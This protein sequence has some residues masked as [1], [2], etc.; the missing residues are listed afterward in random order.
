MAELSV[1]DVFGG[2]EF[3]DRLIDELDEVYPLL[4]PLPS[5]DLATIMYQS[6]QRSVVEYLIQMKANV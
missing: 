2:V 6:G 1:T 4:H 5:D 3:L